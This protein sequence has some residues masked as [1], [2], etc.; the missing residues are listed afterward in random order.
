MAVRIMPEYPKIMDSLYFLYFLKY[1][2]IEY[3][4][5]IPPNAPAIAKYVKF[6]GPILKG[7]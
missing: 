7:D 4:D 5:K 6:V 2:Y 3:N 1:L